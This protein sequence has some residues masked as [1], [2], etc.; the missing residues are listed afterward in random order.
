MR[1]TQADSALAEL[2]QQEVP[3]DVA[4]H[5]YDFRINR[6]GREVEYASIVEVHHPDYLDV[7]ALSDIYAPAGGAVSTQPGGHLDR[8]LRSRPI[9]TQ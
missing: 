2:M 6:A 1:V 9:V 7:D 4:I 8:L 3:F 5:A